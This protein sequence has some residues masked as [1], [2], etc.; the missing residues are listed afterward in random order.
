MNFVVRIMGDPARLGSAV[1][2]VIREIDPLLPVAAVR[3]LE[4]VSAESI[5]RPRLTAVVMSIFAGVALLL[6]VLGV[7]GIVAYLVS[8][9]MREFGIRV[10]FGAQPGQIVNMVVGQNLRIV[11]LGLAAGIVA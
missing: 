4:A 1:V 9:R 7:Y 3:P 8:Q 5:A 6:A 2:R 11:V 10:V